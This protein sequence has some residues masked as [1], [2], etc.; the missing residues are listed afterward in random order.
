MPPPAAARYA[1]PLQPRSKNDTAPS[2]AATSTPMPPPAAARYAAP[3]QPPSKNDTAPSGAEASTPRTPP[4]AARY[5]ALLQPPS[6]TPLPPSQGTPVSPTERGWADFPP[7]SPHAPADAQ[8][9]AQ[10]LPSSFQPRWTSTPTPTPMQGHM[11]VHGQTPVQGQA[12]TQAPVQAP[13]SPS[14]H[15]PFPTPN[16]NEASPGYS[17][18]RLS[19]RSATGRRGVPAHR[20]RRRARYRI[21]CVP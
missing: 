6:G 5:A 2:G 20:R 13:A 15:L 17:P 18:P 16:Q 4:A 9:A 21:R 7:G 1:A 3:S 19:P 10:T 8:A 14:Q 12:P 11:P